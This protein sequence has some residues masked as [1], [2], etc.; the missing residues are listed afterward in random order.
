MEKIVV[1]K[2]LYPA[3]LDPPRQLSFQDQFAFRPTGSTTAAIISILQTISR[4]LET[5][6]YV[7]V[8]TWLQ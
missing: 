5:N 3:I 8:C 2:F 7:V 6:P 1:R 4:L